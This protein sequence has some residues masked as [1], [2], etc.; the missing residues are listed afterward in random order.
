MPVKL[1][2][3]LQRVSPHIEI[4]R[5]LCLAESFFCIGWGGR[6]YGAGCRCEVMSRGFVVYDFDMSKKRCN[7]AVG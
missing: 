6:K 4:P 7:I 3:H 2:L 5:G 1:L